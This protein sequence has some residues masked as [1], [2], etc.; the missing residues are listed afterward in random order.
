MLLRMSQTSQN[1]AMMNRANFEL[2]GSH[3]RD[4]HSWS[5]RPEK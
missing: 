1:Y 2:L 4:A 3:P 5:Q